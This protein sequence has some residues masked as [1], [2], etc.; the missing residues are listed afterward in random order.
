MLMNFSLLIKVDKMIL[1][2]QFSG[3]LGIDGQLN[4]VTK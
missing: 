2:H 4:G 3:Y 1:V